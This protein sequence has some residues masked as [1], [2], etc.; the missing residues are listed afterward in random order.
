MVLSWIK[1]PC[2]IILTMC[3]V[4]AMTPVSAADYLQ[5]V[6]NVVSS[7]YGYFH[8]TSEP[9][10]A[11]VVFD[12]RYVGETPVTVPVFS[13]GSPGHTISISKI[14][15]VTWTRSY[16]QNPVPGETIQVFAPLDPTSATGSVRVSSSPSGALVSL[17]GTKGQMAPWVFSGV[18]AGDHVIQAFLSGFSPFSQTVR[19]EPGKTAEVQAVLLPLTSTGSLQVVTTP[20]GADLY[21]GTIYY[22][23]TSITIGSLATGTHAIL[24]RETG[25]DD[26]T[27]NITIEPGKT[28]YLS[29]TLTPYQKPTTGSL[30]IT[31]NPAGAS[32]FIDG[33]YKGVT[34]AD[35][36]TAF[37][38][39]LPGIH[40]VELKLPNY[41][42]YTGNIEIVAGVTTAINASL[43]ASPNPAPYA[44]VEI[45]SIPS[46]AQVF[47]DGTLQGIT[48]EN[49]PSVPAGTHTFLVRLP[50][51]SDY[52][53]TLSLTP[54]KSAIISA[55]LAPLPTAAPTTTAWGFL[56]VPAG[57]IILAIALDAR[58][59]RRRTG[60]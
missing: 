44:S 38:G 13:S 16:S 28:T 27:G 23:K 46:G 51:Y 8:V 25:Y 2:L 48:P 37:T 9:P 42:G 60:K 34:H 35:E 31:S 58:A 7:D 18:T 17:D 43:E 47:M 22:G 50:G 4:I 55:A 56:S 5:P 36:P 39:I 20:G 29:F 45:D 1:I 11:D 32:I 24:I 33:S 30:R 53:T 19:V 14:G 6:Q 10:G 40:S 26:L 21:I 41:Q 52:T 49:L 12:D 54:G 3:G 59:K 15:Y 57:V